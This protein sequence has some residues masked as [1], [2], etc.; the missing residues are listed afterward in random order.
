MPIRLKDESTYPPRFK[1]RRLRADDF[2]ELKKQI[3]VLLKA[4]FI[5]PSNSP[6]GA[7]VLFVAKKGGQ[8]RFAV[9]YRALNDL[10]IPDVTPLP[11][12][13]DML[14]QLH[15][16][17]IFSKI[18]MTW[19]FWQLRI[20]EADR[21]KSAMTTPLGHF[22]WRVVPFGLTNAPGHCMNVISDVLRPMLFKFAMVLLDDI[23]IY[24]RSVE[25]HLS[26]L[27]QVFEALEKAKFF[28][29]RSK[30]E[31]CVS[32]LHY[33]GHVVSAEG[34]EAEGGKLLSM[35]DFPVSL[36][37]LDVRVFFFGT[38]RVLQKTGSGL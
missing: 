3:A 15:G 10:T 32:R 29:K 38:H 13:D 34:I 36:T 28:I 9:D 26:H 37:V 12:V 11:I 30:C 8:R 5:V 22:D 16:S 17:T 14:Q 23:I 24:S 7:P 20:R 6:F 19:M 31:F 4:N 2:E 1:P 33:L 25:E 27:S 35:R 21:H 18:D